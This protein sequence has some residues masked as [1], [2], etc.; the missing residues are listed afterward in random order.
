M[1]SQKWHILDHLV[2]ALRETGGIEFLH[3]ALYEGSHK[4][5]QNVFRKSSRSWVSTMNEPVKRNSQIL[6]M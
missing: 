5:F 6:S 3:C 2:D 1:G 4:D